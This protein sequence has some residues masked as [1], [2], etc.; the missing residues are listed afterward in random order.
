M[1]VL[2][3]K[4]SIKTD[5]IAKNNV[6]QFDICHF[7]NGVFFGILNARVHFHLALSNVIGTVQQYTSSILNA[8]KEKR[9]NAIRIQGVSFSSL[10]CYFQS[11]FLFKNI[12]YR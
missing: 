9:H 2:V 6:Q 5:Q 8:L 10:K 4:C 12:Q 7:T 1:I 3:A 11:L